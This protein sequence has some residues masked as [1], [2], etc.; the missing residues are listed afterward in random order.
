[1]VGNKSFLPQLQQRRQRRQRRQQR[2]QQ[3]QQ[4]QQRQKR[5]GGPETVLVKIEF[6]QNMLHMAT[7]QHVSSC[8]PLNDSQAGFNLQ[9]LWLI[10]LTTSTNYSIHSV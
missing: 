6:Y 3:Q 1:M 4:Q 5:P 8:M 10:I 9:K 2:Q 7:L